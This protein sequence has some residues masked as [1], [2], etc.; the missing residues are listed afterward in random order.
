MRWQS[1]EDPTV[2]II[3]HEEAENTV[4]VYNAEEDNATI[5]HLSKAELEF[6]FKLVVDE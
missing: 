2:I 6:N 1:K 4:A 3:V 5:F